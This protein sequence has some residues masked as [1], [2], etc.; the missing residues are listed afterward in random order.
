MGKEPH[1][2][3]SRM[4]LISAAIVLLLA[5]G[6][7]LAS[8]GEGGASDTTTSSGGAATTA[9]G[10]GTSGATE[11]NQ[12]VMRNL[13]FEPATIT[14]SAGDTVTWTNEDSTSHTV[15]ADG[16]EFDSGSLANGDSFSFTFET[17][18]T[19]AYHCSIHP[20]MEGTVVVQ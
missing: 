17:A 3:R 1:D 19:I 4:L 8:C 13:S 20:T 9:G 7:V 14:V 10:T 11:G 16:G 2:M 12:V 6:L 5:I 15:T 18:G